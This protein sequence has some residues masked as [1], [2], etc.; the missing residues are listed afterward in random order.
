MFS[1]M[2][3]FLSGYKEKLLPLESTDSTNEKIKK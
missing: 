2:L 3:M 1:F